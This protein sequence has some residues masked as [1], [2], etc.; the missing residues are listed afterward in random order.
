MV[1]GR[2]GY[3]RV[4]K[5]ICYYF[6]KNVLLVATELHFAYMNGFSG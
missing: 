4:A 6:Y 2:N 5:M 1:H 3:I